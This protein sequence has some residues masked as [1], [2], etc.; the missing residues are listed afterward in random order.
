MRLLY[1]V[2]SA[3]MAIQKNTVYSTGGFVSSTVIPNDTFGN[4]FDELSINTLKNARNEYRAIVLHNDG[5]E[6]ATN[7]KIWFENPE[8]NICAYKI[9]AVGLTETENGERYMESIPNIYSRPFIIQLYDATPEAPVSVG[10][11]QPGQMIGLWIERSIDKE[12]AIEEYNNVAERDLTT[13]T[14]YKPVEKQTQE[15]LNIQFYWE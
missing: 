10:D 12:K 4:L 7:V 9:G 1:T 14:R 2:S 15:T 13:E 5:A 8:E 11:V 6:V 3:Y